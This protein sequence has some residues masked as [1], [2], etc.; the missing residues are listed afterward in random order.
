MRLHLK[1]LSPLYLEPTDTGQVWNRDIELD[2]GSSAYVHAVSGRGKTSLVSILC[3]VLKEFRGTAILGDTD[4]R[5]LNPDRWRAI[6]KDTLSVVFQ[7][8]KVFEDLTARENLSLKTELTGFDLERACEMATELGIGDKLDR[9]CGSLSLGERQ[10]LAIVRALCQP[11]S[12]LLMDEPFSH[13]DQANQSRAFELIRREC[14][15][16]SAG[17]IMTGLL[18]TDEE[19]FDHVMAL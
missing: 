6:R 8:L 17:L 14:D 13:L 12:W 11:F 3:G 16:R 2:P 10:R 19:S 15:R 4:I 7:D 1:S 9:R 18:Q 5:S